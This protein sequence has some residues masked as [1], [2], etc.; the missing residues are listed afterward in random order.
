MCSIE[1]YNEKS[2]YV[3][4]KNPE[5]TRKIKKELKQL[6]GKWNTKLNAEYGTKFAAWIFPISKQDDVQEFL[7]TG[8]LPPVPIKYTNDMLITRIDYL[9]KMLKDHEGRIYYLEK[10]LTKI[11]QEHEDHEGRIESLELSA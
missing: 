4:S 7:K 6:G 9:E 3:T 1:S 2:F 10:N 5:D 11:T 8:F